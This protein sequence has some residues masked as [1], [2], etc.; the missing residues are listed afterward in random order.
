MKLAFA[1]LSALLLVACRDKEP[2]KPTTGAPTERPDQ[3][4]G[5]TVVAQAHDFPVGRAADIQRLF[6]EHVMSYPIAV[7]SKD[8]AQTQFANPKPVFV[9]DSRFVVGLPPASHQ[10][11]D[12]LI[13]G[14]SKGKS[15]L[16]GTYELTFWA[17][18]GVVAPETQVSPDLGDVAPALD[19]LTGLGKR[20]Y[21]SLDRVGARS[22]DGSVTKLTGRM[23]KAEHRLAT[24]GDGIELELTM[25]LL[26][27]AADKAEPTPT[28]E[29]TLH[30]P[31][32]KPIVIGD[33]AQAG[34]S[35]GAA[36][37]LLYVVRARRVD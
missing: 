22:R 17:V 28:I 16:G 19:K 3:T 13:A 4:I 10:A 11:L 23:L 25:Q 6:D 2:P 36:N 14:L 24:G 12:R 37:I 7:V 26:G 29:T 27:G 32:D 8:G 31:L 20:R 34:A 21:K 15:S 33:T 5:G 9:S 30:L 1:A 18:E 35:D